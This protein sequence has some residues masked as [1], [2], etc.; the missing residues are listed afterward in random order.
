MIDSPLA[1]RDDLAALVDRSI[2][3]RSGDVAGS[4]RFAMLESLRQYGTI[5]LGPDQLAAARDAH[6]AHFTEFA[7]EADAGIRPRSAVT[8]RQY[9]SLSTIKDSASGRART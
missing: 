8:N 7:R 2:L 9:C 6:L 4:A 5:E 3:T 1:I